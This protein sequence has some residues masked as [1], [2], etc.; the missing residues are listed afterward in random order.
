MV[1]RCSLCLAVVHPNRDKNRDKLSG[2]DT[3]KSRRPKTAS[4][5]P[6]VATAQRSDG[7][8]IPPSQ[9]K[10]EY[11]API[12]SRLGI[13]ASKTYCYFYGDQ[14]LFEERMGEVRD[15][16]AWGYILGYAVTTAPPDPPPPEALQFA[17]L[18]LLPGVSKREAE[19]AL[20]R[21]FASFPRKPQRR[22][23]DALSQRDHQLLREIF[24]LA[25]SKAGRP[26]RPAVLI[27]L[28]DAICKVLHKGLDYRRLSKK[29]IEKE[30][31]SWRKETGRP[32]R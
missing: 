31:E 7:R 17:A 10:Q 21:I 26:L 6:R 15:E 32:T 27:P 2:L 14:S 1:S 29:T 3:L 23:P 30:C 25:E 12:R 11:S 16:A 20:D 5:T 4:P 19:K 8:R 9:S 28:A 18:Y 24:E 22:R 13:S